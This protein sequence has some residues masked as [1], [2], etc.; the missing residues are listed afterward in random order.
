MGQRLFI[1][2]MMLDEHL[3]WTDTCR[4]IKL[5]H[6]L[7][8]HT[9]INSKQIKDLNIR[10]ETIKVLEENLSTKILGTSHNLGKGN[11]RK[12]NKW[13]YIKLKQF[14]TAKETINKIKRQCTEWGNIFTD[15]SDTADKRLLSK[16]YKEFTKLNPKKTKQ[17]N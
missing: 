12:T 6:L 16:I 10:P 1:Q 9:R 15:T 17:S 2:Y 7:T 14:C 3:N 8:L 13:D 5:D 4:K 11:K